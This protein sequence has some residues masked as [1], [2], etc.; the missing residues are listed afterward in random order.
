VYR[1]LHDLSARGLVQRNP[2]SP[3]TFTAAPPE[4]G[5][6]ILL[7]RYEQKLASL[8]AKKSD[9]IRSLSSYAQ[10]GDDER[11]ERFSLVTGGGNLIERARQMIVNARAEYVGIMSKYG[12]RR[13][14]EVG[15]TKAILD[16]KR[17][18]V[19]IRLVSE[20]DSENKKNADYLAK[21]IEFRTNENLS[22][23][24]TIIDH[25]ELLIGP[26]ITDQEAGERNQREAD[27]WT[28]NHAFISGMYSFFE[29]LW[30]V[31]SR[32]EPR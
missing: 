10:V 26:A 20:V 21:H 19:K 12:M 17:R 14:K 32:Y 13:V 31:S 4:R 9:L 6:D 25:R 16:A 2:G 3:S 1:V 23:Y 5:I 18:G 29:H 15:T 30:K 11:Y 7:K 8:Q 28:N 24:L 22:Y 27:L